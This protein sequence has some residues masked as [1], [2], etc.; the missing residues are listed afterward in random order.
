MKALVIG[1]SGL[2]GS[3]LI[4]ALAE[5]GI[6]TV[7]T[8]WQR[9]SPRLVRL[10]VS[11]G[12]AVSD[13][14]ATVRPQMVFLAAAMVRAERCEDDPEMAWTV[15][16]EGPLHAALAASAHKAKLVFYSTDAVFD[17]ERGPY[18]EED[19]AN[20]LSVYGRTKLAA[21]EAIREAG[22]DYI[23]VRT[24]AVFGWDRESKNFAMQ[25]WESLRAGRQ[26]RVASDQWCNPTLA[27]YLAET[28]VRLALG[29]HTGVINV[30]GRDLMP[31]SEFAY[32]LADCLGLDRG[33]IAPA[34]LRE[35]GRRASLPL[36]AGLTTGRLRALG[37]EPM[38]LDEAL[39]RFRSRQQADVQMAGR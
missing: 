19:A 13:L 5:A 27:D 14:V 3:A 35:A 15:N 23:I 24:T 26:V 12:G 1:A 9:P 7:G 22:Q 37:V 16:A 34:P 21:E 18:S 2:A 29:G 36:R 38:G 6:D 11:D 25:L 31:R 30:V 33:L 17:G 20:P 4:R 10:D 32:R 28:S 39:N 8:Y